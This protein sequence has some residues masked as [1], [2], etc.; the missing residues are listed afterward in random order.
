MKYLLV[1]RCFNKF[2]FAGIEILKFLQ[3]NELRHNEHEVE[4]VEQ[5]NLFNPLTTAQRRTDEV[6]R[7]KAA[8]N[9]FGIASIQAA[10]RTLVAFQGQPSDVM[11]DAVE[12]LVHLLGLAEQA[13]KPEALDSVVR[14][15]DHRMGL[16]THATSKIDDPTFRRKVCSERVASTSLFEESDVKK[17]VDSLE[18]GKRRLVKTVAE[19]RQ[20][21]GVVFPPRKRQNTGNQKAQQESGPYR[22]REKFRQNKMFLQDRFPRKYPNYK[23]K[24]FNGAKNFRGRGGRYGH[25]SKRPGQPSQRGGGHGPRRD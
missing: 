4:G 3:A 8:T 6:L 7:R 1:E 12:P 9:L 21:E 2:F 10:V 22:N 23:N 17:A 18:H 19:K 20:A 13:L 16:R 15:K 25:T 5:D 14:A 24:E 11:R